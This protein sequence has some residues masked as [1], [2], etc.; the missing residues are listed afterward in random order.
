MQTPWDDVTETI[1][2]QNKT[3]GRGSEMLQHH[4]P[5]TLLSVKE[6]YVLYFCFHGDSS[7]RQR[8]FESLQETHHFS[9]YFRH[10]SIWGIATSP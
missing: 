3:K 9:D 10:T 5:D 1:S 7:W 6:I 4:S 8:S 2:K